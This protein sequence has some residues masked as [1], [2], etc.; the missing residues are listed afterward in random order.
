MK[1][2]FIRDCKGNIVGNLKGYP[3]YKGAERQ[4]EMRT[5]K[6]HKAIWLAFNANEANLDALGDPKSGRLVYEIKLEDAQ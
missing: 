3:T 6:A 5:A 1:R 2:Y 4:A